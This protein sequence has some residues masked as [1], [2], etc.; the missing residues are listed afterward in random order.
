[1]S[2]PLRVLAIIASGA[3]S[4]NALTERFRIPLSR[5]RIALMP[6]RTTPTN[7]A[8][9]GRTFVATTV[10]NRRNTGASFPTSLKTDLS[11]GIIARAAR[12]IDWNAFGALLRR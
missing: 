1:M 4:A 11:A 6:L 2:G 5:F 10:P 8:S 9:G 3:A 12:C 7:V